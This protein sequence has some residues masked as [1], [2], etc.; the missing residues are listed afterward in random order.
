MNANNVKLIQ[1][2]NGDHCVRIDGQVDHSLEGADISIGQICSDRNV[3]TTCDWD[4]P[5]TCSAEIADDVLQAIRERH[6][7]WVSLRLAPL[8]AL[9]NVLRP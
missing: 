7:L 2:G 3:H 5:Y 8:C 1:W 4:L 9:R 6:A